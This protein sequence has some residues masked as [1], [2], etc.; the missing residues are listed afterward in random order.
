M[1]LQG[2]I[3]GVTYYFEHALRFATDFTPTK[4]DVLKSRL[5]TTGVIEVIFEKKKLFFFSHNF[6]NKARLNLI[7]KATVLQL[8]TLV[9]NAVKEKSGSTVSVQ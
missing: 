4:D 5:K 3:S 2:G 8:L 9:A 6:S 1:T 7:W